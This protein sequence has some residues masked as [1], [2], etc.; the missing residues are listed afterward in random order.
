MKQM[1]RGLLTLGLGVLSALTM[2]A[3]PV[4]DISSGNITRDYIYNN[5]YQAP[6][7]SDSLTLSGSSGGVDF[8]IGLL[9]GTNLTYSFPSFGST[10]TD[11]IT[12]SFAE[13]CMPSC[14]LGTLA[15]DVQATLNG[16]SYPQGCLYPCQPHAP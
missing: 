14:V 1:K 11:Q 5:W 3:G 4:T 15:L 12:A 9:P 2:R 13:L 6:G 16:F 10:F 7:E 8:S